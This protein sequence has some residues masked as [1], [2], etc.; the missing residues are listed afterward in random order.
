[1]NDDQ[2]LVAKVYRTIF[3][4]WLLAMFWSLGLY[5]PWIALSIT[6]GTALGT[7][8]IVTFA[9][10]VRKAFVP[11]AKRPGNALIKLALV[12]YPLM[13]LALYFIVHMPGINIPAFCGGVILTH[14]AI[15]AKLAGVK[16]MERE[17]TRRSQ[18]D[19]SASVAVSK[20][21]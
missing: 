2:D 13:A 9:H 11:G 18:E 4:T 5:K 6:L 7:G 3:F 14:F 12:K 16:L 19:K 1:M 10:V 8:V 17:V 20:E 15:L 21:S